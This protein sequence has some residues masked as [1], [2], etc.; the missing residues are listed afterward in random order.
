M[1]RNA[2]ST[3]HHFITSSVFYFLVVMDDSLSI[4]AFD[5]LKGHVDIDSS[6]SF[7]KLSNSEGNPALFLLVTNSTCFVKDSLADTR[8]KRGNVGP[9]A[10]C[11]ETLSG[12]E[13]LR[14]KISNI[15]NEESKNI[16][17][18][19]VLSSSSHSTELSADG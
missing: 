6:T 1:V 12:N 11:L 16:S 14:S 3:K 13:M 10:R 7:V 8:A 18:H 19:S 4:T 5:V 15:G 9:R 2:A 17:L